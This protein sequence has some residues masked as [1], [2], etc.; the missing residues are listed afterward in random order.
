MPIRIDYSPVGT[1]MNLA[2]SAGE[3][4]GARA[5]ASQDLAFT[6]MALQAQA[7]NNQI[8]ASMAMQQN[9]QAFQLQRAAL[10]RQQA[11][12][13]RAM[14]QA[15]PVADQVL[16]RM[17]VERGWEQLD[18]TTQMTQLDTLAQ[19]GQYTE[20]QIE[21]AR[22]AVMGGQSPAQY[23]TQKKEQEG[24]T[25]SQRTTH[26]KTL[27]LQQRDDLEA[28]RES[29]YEELKYEGA[30]RTKDWRDRL[31]TASAKITTHDTAYEQQV[32]GERTPST[33]TGGLNLEVLNKPQPLPATK[34]DLV[35][36]QIYATEGGRLERWTGSHLAEIK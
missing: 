14:A 5:S 7:Q 9:S 13:T 17:A 27:W 30:T 34:A 16:G 31:A 36:G 22:L 21:G 19:S 28:E 4:Q 1:L 23:L 11:T 29:I 2:R 18:Q 8:S 3:A 26:A 33:T 12:P 6:Q 32:L 20:A 25:P 15:S 10:S 24:L 35:V